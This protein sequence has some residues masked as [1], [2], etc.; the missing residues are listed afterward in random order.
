VASPEPADVLRAQ[1]D[2]A[3]AFADAMRPIA[4]AYLRAFAQL[5]E[6]LAVFGRQL[7][8]ALD[9]SHGERAE[10]GDPTGD[11]PLSRG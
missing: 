6:S 1:V 3:A 8:A 4:E 10:R 9:A 7:T 5:G 2:A 11:P